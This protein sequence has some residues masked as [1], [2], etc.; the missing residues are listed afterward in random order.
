M[1]VI[2]QKCHSPMKRINSITYKCTEC[3]LEEEILFNIPDE[4]KEAYPFYNKEI[5]IG[6][7]PD[8]GLY[9]DKCHHSLLM[10]DNFMLSDRD[11]T[12]NEDN[13]SIGVDCHCPYCGSQYSIAEHN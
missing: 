9:C 13:D 8:S 4:E 5:N 11:K 1:D 12:V 2:C 7:E 6:D 3:N 10:E